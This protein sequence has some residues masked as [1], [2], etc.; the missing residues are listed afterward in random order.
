MHA[1]ENHTQ[2][3][4]PRW[5]KANAQHPSFISL[6]ISFY[7]KIVRFSFDQKQQRKE[8]YRLFPFYAVRMLPTWN[9]QTNHGKGCNNKISLLISVYKNIPSFDFF[10]FFFINYTKKTIEPQFRIIIIKKKKITGLNR[11][12]TDIC[13]YLNRFGR[14]HWRNKTCGIRAKS[15][16]G[17]SPVQI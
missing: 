1:H 2:K 8:N 16:W 6:S 10:F 15:V 7:F 11:T 5:R 9:P 13:S 4:V 17:A 12:C 14:K 3:S